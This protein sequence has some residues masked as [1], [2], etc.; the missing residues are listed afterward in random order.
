MAVWITQSGFSPPPCHVF[1]WVV[2]PEAGN[3][4]STTELIELV[5]FEVD[6]NLLVLRDRFN[7]ID[8]KRR[9]AFWAFESKIVVRLDNEI[10][11]KGQVEVLGPG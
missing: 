11:T 2:K 1:W 4:K 5:R 8:G 9:L 10:Q 7:S 6:G 3:D